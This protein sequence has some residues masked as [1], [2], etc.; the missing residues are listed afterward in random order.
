MGKGGGEG[1]YRGGGSIGR[2]LRPFLVR[3]GL[4]T[5]GFAVTCLLPG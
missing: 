4:Y 1:F 2:S 5:Q 3:A